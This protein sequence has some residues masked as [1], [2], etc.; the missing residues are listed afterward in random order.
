VTQSAHRKALDILNTVG[1]SNSVLRLI[2]RRNR[3]DQWIKYAG[4]LLT[5]IFLFAFVFWRHWSSFSVRCWKSETSR[6]IF[7]R[8]KRNFNSLC[9]MWLYNSCNCLHH[10]HFTKYILAYS[11]SLHYLF[12][13]SIL[14]FNSQEMLDKT[15]FEF[16]WS[17]KTIVYYILCA[18]VPQYFFFCWE[19]SIWLLQS[20]EQ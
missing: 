8:N 14:D 9:V 5:L 17:E 16:T 10:T 6:S 7:G 2:E 1:I 13:F 11:R 12:P 15:D 3:V 18:L 19:N 20:W 4:M